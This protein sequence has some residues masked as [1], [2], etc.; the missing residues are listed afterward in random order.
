MVDYTIGAIV[1]APVVPSLML[2]IVGAIVVL[3][4]LLVMV[5]ATVVPFVL[6]VTVGAVVVTLPIVPISLFTSDG[7]SLLAA[8]GADVLFLFVT[9]GTCVGA[10]PVGTCTVPVGVGVTTVMIGALVG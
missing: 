9:V 6:L 3:F 1:G 7:I 8:A 4:V 10:V 2:G 5:G